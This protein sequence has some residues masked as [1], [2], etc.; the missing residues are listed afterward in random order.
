MSTENKPGK[1][2]IG[3]IVWRDLTVENAAEIKDFYA[4]VVGWEA[5]PHNM[6]AYD[7]FDIIAPGTSERVAGVC[8]ARDS[9]ANLPAQWL[10][11]ITVADVAESAKRCLARGGKILD[12]PRMMGASHFCVIQDPAGAVAAL[13][14]E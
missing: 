12:G 3:T 9:N 5:E 2:Q 10:I 11:Y 8:H 4:D 13:I 1:P 6:G 14:S 7:D